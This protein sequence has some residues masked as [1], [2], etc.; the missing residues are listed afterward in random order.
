MF[1]PGKATATPQ[2]LPTTGLTPNPSPRGEGSSMPCYCC[3][4][5]SINRHF[6]FV[7][8]TAAIHITPL[9]PWRGAG[10]EASCGAVVAQLWGQL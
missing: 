2:L 8:F 3:E 9:S 1:Y 7:S 4:I 6:C 10:G 5:T